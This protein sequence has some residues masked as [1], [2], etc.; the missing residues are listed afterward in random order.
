MWTAFVWRIVFLSPRRPLGGSSAL[1]Q[2]GS[3]ECLLIQSYRTCPSLYQLNQLVDIKPHAARCLFFFWIC[4]PVRPLSLATAAPSPVN[5]P[6]YDHL[7][8]TSDW[9]SGIATCWY[10]DLRSSIVREDLPWC[11]FS[12]RPLGGSGLR[13]FN[14]ASCWL[15]SGPRLLFVVNSANLTG[16]TV[17]IV[18]IYLILSIQTIE[19]E[20]STPERE[21]S[22]G[23]FHN[24]AAAVLWQRMRL[25][26]CS[27]PAQRLP[28]LVILVRLWPLCLGPI[29]YFSW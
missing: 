27:V 16:R 29:Q 9:A 28:V 17:R 20:T 8:M 21:M 18:H 3:V 11:Q 26:L 2:K 4:S 5:V 14:R 7:K 19:W 1:T 10:G 15:C 24:I 13:W 23:L 22:S 6:H 25:W 12:R